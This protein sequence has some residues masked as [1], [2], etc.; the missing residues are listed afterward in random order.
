[1][2]KKKITKKVTKKPIKNKKKNSLYSI[3]IVKVLLI[4]VLAFAIYHNSQTFSNT[5]SLLAVNEDK[6]GNVFGGSTIDLHLEIRPGTGETFVNLNTA[7]ETDTQ[8]SIVKS[9]DIA[10]RL[11]EL[12]CSKYDFYF[13]FDG[14]SV[15]LKGPSASS[16]IALLSAKTVN[17]I[18][19]D[20]TTVITGTLSS[21]GIIGNVGGTD[22]KIQ[23]AK[24]NGFTKVLIPKFSDFNSSV[25]G[26]E[27]VKVLDIID[28]Y[29]E[30]GE[31]T[32]EIEKVKLDSENYNDLMK[33]LAQDM[34][35]RTNEIKS[36]INE[37][38]ITNTSIEYGFLNQMKRS[39][40]SSQLAF[41]V[42]NYYSQ[43][44]FCYNA[45]IN[46]RI[47]V[48]MQKNQS[49]EDLNL[50]SNRLKMEI[51]R[52]SLEI[53][54]EDYIENLETI[55]DFYVYLLITDRITE[56]AEIVNN[57]EVVNSASNDVSIRQKINGYST[58]K[59]RLYTVIVWEKFMSHSG[60]MVKISG[61]VVENACARITR[62]LNFNSQI[63]KDYN[64]DIFDE[65]IRDQNGY[66]NSDTGDKYLCIYKGLELNGR[67]NTI[68][69]SVG[70]DSNSSKL[71]AREMINLTQERLS[72][73]SHN[74]FPLIPY[75]YYE[76]S[77]DLVEG[78][79]GSSLLYSNYA[80]SY[81]DLNLYID[82]NNKNSEFFN[83]FMKKIMANIY[84]VVGMLFLI[85]FLS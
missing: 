22:E 15:L 8:V 14:S 72:L 19:V 45:N 69:N 49:I 85:A 30:F 51:K 46:G 41:E 77:T 62:E 55:N 73:N 16:A 36:E 29:N 7:T 54:E 44:S 67:M 79:V 57:L 32:Y 56:A 21:G 52:K 27:V 18:K 39:Y 75:I 76:Y 50:M 9:K 42:G 33:V 58:A 37:E 81:I 83:L 66:S 1:M 26:I 6:N 10:C 2:S 38:L 74:D 40:N 13:N 20:N 80:L 59:E 43:G 34:C 4:L 65:A 82:E 71:F 11:F 53:K 64:I 70:I 35:S 3:I 78:D 61:E 12:D 60:D 84:F 17:K 47:I 68:L 23:V 31:D 25:E 5:I 63:L 24:K 48:E 28:V